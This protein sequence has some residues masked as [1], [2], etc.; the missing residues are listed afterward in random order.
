MGRVRFP[1]GFQW[2]TATASA[3]IEGAWQ[4]DGKSPSIW[5]RFAHTPGRIKNGDTPDVACDSYH[6][7][8]E[9][10]ALMRE[11][12]LTSYRFSISWPR[13][14]PGGGGPVNARGVDYYGRLVDALLDAG[15]RP[16]PTLYHWDLPQTLQDRGGWPNRDTA[17][18]FADYAAAV[19]RALSDRVSHWIIFNEP[20]IFTT[21]GYLAGIHAPGIRDRDAFLRAG[22]TVNLAQGEAFRAMRSERSDAVIGT[23]FSMSPCE[24]AGDAAADAAAAER[25]H[26]LVNLWYLEPALRG[27]YPH[28]FV[29]GPPLEAMGVREGDM[30]L[31]RAPLDFLGINLYTRTLVEARPGDAGGL[32]AW[33]VGPVGGGEGPKTDFGWEVWPDA[34]YDMILRITRDYDR[35]VIEVT[36]NGCTTSA[37]STST[38]DTSPRW[39]GPSRTAQTCAAITPGRCSTTSSGPRATTS[40]SAWSGSTSRIAPGPSRPLAAGTEASPRRTASR[41]DGPRE[42]AYAPGPA[43]TVDSFDATEAT[44]CRHRSFSSRAHPPASAGSARSTFPSAT[45]ASTEPVGVPDPPRRERRV[46]ARE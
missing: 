11:M 16:F 30:D 40:A 4:E 8:P 29:D 39:P 14:L 36:E 42:G 7:F 15:I 22:H 10:V 43:R 1:E 19:M 17:G 45:T 46:R 6:R 23:A 25:W 44:R 9:D 41:R 34:L 2:G 35:P 27:R 32:D 24:P 21:M 38:T 13:I 28:A 20:S 18:R 12:N 5:D 26:G 3:Q 31:V 37:A 33:A